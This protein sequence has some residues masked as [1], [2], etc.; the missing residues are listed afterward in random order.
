MTVVCIHML[1]MY[2]VHRVVKL[3]LEI[4]L[5]FSVQGMIASAHALQVKLES[6]RILTEAFTKNPVSHI[7]PYDNDTIYW[8]C[9][10]AS[11]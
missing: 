5:L 11:C 3:E 7:I 2:I 9:E 6:E 1:L 4:I 8:N 10:K